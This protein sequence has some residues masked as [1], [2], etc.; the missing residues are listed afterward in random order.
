MAKVKR[1]PVK[2]IP[3]KDAMIIHKDVMSGDNPNVV[4]MIL[5]NHTIKSRVK[6]LEGASKNLDSKIHD[7]RASDAETA[8]RDIADRSGITISRSE[9]PV[10]TLEEEV[11][12][13]ITKAATKKL[14]S[15]GIKD[16]VSVS[17]TIEEK[18]ILALGSLV[19]KDYILSTIS[20]D[21]AQ[22]DRICKLMIDEGIIYNINRRVNK[23]RLLDDLSK[24]T[25]PAVLL[26]HVSISTSDVLNVR[27]VPLK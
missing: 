12:D 14:V 1:I 2:A 9:H 23:N 16:G 15:I 4:D 13:P 5:A 19:P 24:G 17:K 21:E 11:I 26:P 25:L 10:L 27:E 7:C 3:L 18:D 6:I 8:I 22:L 20:V